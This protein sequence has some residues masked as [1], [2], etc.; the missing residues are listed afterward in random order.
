MRQILCPFF[1]ILI[2]FSG[3]STHIAL[4]KS[5]ESCSA[6]TLERIFFGANT[7]TTPLSDHDWQD[8]LKNT[9][10]PKFPAGLT[11]L[12]ANGQWRGNNGNIEREISRIV[13]LI[14]PA[15]DASIKAIDEIIATY[16]ARFQQEAVLLVR[17]PVSACL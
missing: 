4:P 9:V 2:V 8:F 14:H 17:I 7:P 15:D 3:C 6:Q 13:E 5:S 12:N 1:L 16:K 10:T 11:V